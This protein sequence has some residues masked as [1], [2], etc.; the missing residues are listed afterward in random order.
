MYYCLCRVGVMLLLCLYVGYSVMYTECK[1]SLYVY[2]YLINKA[3]SDSCVVSVYLAKT[4]SR[5]P[6]RMTVG[7]RVWDIEANS[8][9]RRRIFVVAAMKEQRATSKQK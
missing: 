3:D 8:K 4:R 5:S 9:R 6:Q 2:T 1:N 7:G